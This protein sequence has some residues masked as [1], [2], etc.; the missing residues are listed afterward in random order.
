[1][2]RNLLLSLIVS[3]C[4]LFSYGERP[5]NFYAQKAAEAMASGEME[6]ALDYA[7]EEI[8]DYP[9]NPR[10]YYEGAQVLYYLNQPGQALTMINKAIEK[11]KKDKK[12]GAQCYYIKGNLLEATGDSA[13]SVQ[14]YAD[15]LKLDSKNVDLLLSHSNAI[16]KQEPAKAFKELQEAKKIA[17]EESQVYAYTAYYYT[18]QNNYK[19][20]LNEITKAIKYDPYSAY[21]YS[22][23]GMILKNLGYTPDW[24]QDCLRSTEYADGL[25]LG[26]LMLAY[27]QDEATREEIIKEIE[28]SRNSFN[29]YYQLE[30]Q[31]LDHWGDY[32]KAAEVYKEMIDMGKAT[33]SIYNSLAEC[34]DNL[35]RVFDA[36]MTAS[37]GL[38]KF[39]DDP[40]LIFTKARLGIDAGK[41]EELL[42]SIDKLIAEYP[43]AANGYYE[44]GRALLS[45]GRYA[46][47]VEPLEMAVVLSP[48]A[49]NQ[50]YYGDA[51]RL[52]G[53]VTKGNH[54]YSEILKKTPQ[55][56][57]NEGFDPFLY[58]AMAYSGMG[59]EEMALKLMHEGIEENPGSEVAFRSLV[60]ARLGNKSEAIK[61]LR[62]YYGDNGNGILSELYDHNFHGLHSEQ[63]FID[64]LAENGIK[65]TLN[66]GTNLLEFELESIDLSSGGTSL[67]EIEDLIASNPTE[68]V[69]EINK[70]CPVDMGYLGQLESLN[71]DEPTKTITYSLITNPG[72]MNFDAFESDPEY[73]QK[74]EEIMM[75]GTL[76]ENAALINSG[77][78]FIYNVR[79]KDNSKKVSLV[80]TPAKI[81]SINEKY[82]SQDDIDKLLLQFW[83][84]EEEQ[85]M[86]NNPATAN[87]ILE[88]N[89]KE[90]SYIY[91]IPDE[92]VVGMELFDSQLKKRLTPFFKDLSLKSKLPVFIRQNISIKFIYRGI[93][94]GKELVIEFTPE[95]FK[96]YI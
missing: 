46:D 60:N 75:L 29:G 42:P 40:E 37:L 62:N 59:N 88:F 19:E 81:K 94:T 39:P 17:P 56:L 16:L 47:A 38:E 65:T 13:Q 20:A 51:L 66:P 63:E 27:E 78:T 44:K 86:K 4:F 49:K 3:L 1:M 76:S 53:D 41:G 58:Y 91:L 18:T 87:T 55:E 15:G 84:D 32:E 28:R 31:I 54:Y 22:L 11:S 9:D 2:R 71:Y 92:N 48:T 10:G 83:K 30:A 26:L 50:L 80:F 23:R 33:A 74:K 69:K 72:V 24:I 21:N 43:E 79:E 61:A 52:S 90:Y 82:S 57:I 6:D 67:E 70:R 85:I 89:G 64:L 35:N 96:E 93:E 7:K 36:Y 68:W 5:Q 77:L 14:A 8:K 34:L 12:F 25:S 95:D 45:I 73:K